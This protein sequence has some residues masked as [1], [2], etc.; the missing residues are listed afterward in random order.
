MTFKY[1]LSEKP[2]L[3]FAINCGKN[4]ADNGQV[5]VKMIFPIHPDWNQNSRSYE[6]CPNRKNCGATIVQ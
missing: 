4:A 6:K 3:T 5:V 2:V 1:I